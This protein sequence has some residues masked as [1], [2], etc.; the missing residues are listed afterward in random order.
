[1]QPTVS[2]ITPLAS[3]HK[4]LLPRV[5]QT[6]RDQT[7]PCDHIIIEDIEQRGAGYCRNR[8]IE[9]AAGEFLVF[10]DADDEI[11][12][13][14]VERCLSTWQPSY[15][16]Y[17]DFRWGDGKVVTDVEKPWRGDGSWHPITTLIPREA[18]LK[19]DGF[20]E[21][22]VGSEDAWFF[23]ELTR[24]GC[25]HIHLREILFHYRHGDGQ[26]AR[27][28]VNDKSAIAKYNKEWQERWAKK[29]GC[30]GD[31]VPAQSDNPTNEY[32]EGAI[33]VRATWG[34]NYIR[35]GLATR[36]QYPRTGDYKQV[37]VDERDVQLEPNAWQPVE[38]PKTEPRRL[39]ASAPQVVTP[40]VEYATADSLQA[41]TARLFPGVAQPIDVTALAAIEPSARGNVSAVL[42]RVGK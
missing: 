29:L 32:F 41:V 14:F 1:M 26:R 22:L 4:H 28:F 12:P 30:C 21:D 11:E 17:T 27:T 18:V 8:G 20:R 34:G 38:P 13:T 24:A 7:V 16:V 40:L 39:N 37:W 10:L 19:V 33:L 9:Q 2:I 35:F 6:V 31:D 25:C 42:K 5:Q 36:R 23:Y 15:Y 3:Y